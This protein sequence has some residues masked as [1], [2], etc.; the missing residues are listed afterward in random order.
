MSRWWFAEVNYCFTIRE[1]LLLE[2]IYWVRPDS[3][4]LVIPGDRW[5][6]RLKLFSQAT[7]SPLQRNSQRDQL[8]PSGDA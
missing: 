3:V 7:L 5:P 1:L 6:A 4:L 2:I 8:S